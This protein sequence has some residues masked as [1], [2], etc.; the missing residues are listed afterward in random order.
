MNFKNYLP[1]EEKP[2]EE[3]GRG[4]IASRY[5]V[6]TAPSFFPSGSLQ[7]VRLSLVQCLMRISAT[8][9]VVAMCQY[10]THACRSFPLCTREVPLLD[11]ESALTF[12]VPDMVASVVHAMDHLTHDPGINVCTPTRKFS[13]INYLFL[14]RVSMLIR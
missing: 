10:I 14:Y 2:P 3:I 9:L 4:S 5:Q 6:A 13:F 7:A 8:R 11:M 12:L 1:M